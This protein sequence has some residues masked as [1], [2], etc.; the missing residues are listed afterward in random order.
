ME[1]RMKRFFMSVVMGLL[2]LLVFVACVYEDIP[3]AIG[4]AGDKIVLAYEKYNAF[5]ELLTPQEGQRIAFNMSAYSRIIFDDLELMIPM[6]I[7][8]AAYGLDEFVMRLVVMLAG[9]D[10]PMEYYF[11]IRDGEIAEFEVAIDFYLLSPDEIE[12]FL[13]DEETVRFLFD[14]AHS[15]PD[16]P[17]FSMDSILYADVTEL[18]GGGKSVVLILRGEDMAD[19]ATRNIEFAPDDDMVL[20]FMFINIQS[21]Q[22][23]IPFFMDSHMNASI[24]ERGVVTTV[25][26]ETIYDFWGIGDDVVI[27]PISVRPWWLGTRN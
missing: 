22:D 4:Q 5:L 12:V 1:D 18:R 15:M 7:R 23:G 16:M 20:E 8:F 14:T 13:Q 19:F 3:P 6:A 26:T 21:S 11:V 10:L 17:I 24:I 9:L 27:Y 25:R 2:A